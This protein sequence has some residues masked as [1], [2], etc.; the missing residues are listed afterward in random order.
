MQETARATFKHHHDTIS[1]FSSLLQSDQPLHD[2]V[3][4]LGRLLGRG[5]N[6]EVYECEI[7]IRPSLTISAAAKKIFPLFNPEL[8]QIVPGSAEHQHVINEFL[9]EVQLL[10][11]NKHAHIVLSYGYTTSPANGWPGTLLLER[12]STTLQNMLWPEGLQGPL[13]ALKEAKDV[14]WFGSD[15]LNGLDFLHRQNVIHRDIKP[16]NILMFEHG[17]TLIAKLGDLGL[18][19][20]MDRSYLR[21]VGGAVFYMAP[22]GLDRNPMMRTASDIY[23]FGIILIEMAV[24]RSPNIAARTQE[25]IRETM[26]QSIFCEVAVG[27]VRFKWE[28]RWSAAVTLDR[29]RALR[30]EVYG[31]CG[32][33]QGVGRAVWECNEAV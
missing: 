25:D 26:G 2:N 13:Q 24:G 4:Q 16:D 27:T 18:G 29:L 17:G 3:V 6:G 15:I 8:Y 20:H 9:T 32:H 1:K 10:Q 23:S 21:E 11:Q 30:H 33:C 31:Q 14:Y 5:A 22:E 12:A 7:T 28:Q 19:R